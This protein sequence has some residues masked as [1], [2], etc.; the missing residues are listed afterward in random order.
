MSANDKNVKE[1]KILL[2]TH[3]LIWYAEGINLSTNQIGLIEN[4]R[5]KKELY[6]SAISIW[7]ITMLANRSKLI[8]SIDIHDWI[9]K[10]LSTL[11]LELIDLS[12]PILIQ[13]CELPNYPHRDPA[14]RMIIATSRI[15]N[16]ALMTL[17][18][19]II[20]YGKEGYFKLIDPEVI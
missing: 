10:L 11:G 19:K 5:K 6:I 7:E 4:T 17:D 13:S 8:F 20:D 14:D 3:I 9:K 15:N 2:D 18:R 16:I 1:E 12:V